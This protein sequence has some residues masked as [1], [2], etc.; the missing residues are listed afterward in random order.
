MQANW[1]SMMSFLQRSAK[2]ISGLKVKVGFDFK[3]LNI[4]SDSKYSQYPEV[5]I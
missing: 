3:R 2:E 1:L 4:T 5:G